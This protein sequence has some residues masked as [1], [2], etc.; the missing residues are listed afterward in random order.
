MNPAASAVNKAGR[1]AIVTSLMVCC[2]F[3]ICWSPNA[4]TFF[5][6][7][8]GYSVD[9]GGWFYHFIFL[10]FSTNRVVQQSAP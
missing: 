5:L 8:A 7:F 4:I 10:Y 1:N 9:F 2:G 6:H 3:V